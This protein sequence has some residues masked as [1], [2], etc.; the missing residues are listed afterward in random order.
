MGQ[1]INHAITTAYNVLGNFV[2]QTTGIPSIWIRCRLTLLGSVGVDG[3]LGERLR[4]NTNVV[5]VTFNLN[6]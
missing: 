2:V 1:S 5:A 4:E 6:L 3:K